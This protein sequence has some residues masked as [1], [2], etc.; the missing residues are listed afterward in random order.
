MPSPLTPIPDDLPFAFTPRE[1]EHLGIG[2]NVLSHPRF[3]R[4]FR[5]VRV[6]GDGSHTALV[7]SARLEFLARSYAPRLRAGE[8]FS[9]GTALVLLG[10]PIRP[11][12]ALDVASPPPLT[13]PRSR[14]VQ[15][16]RVRVAIGSV[17]G[18]W[19]LPVAAPAEAVMQAAAALPFTELVVAIDFLVT[20]QSSRTHLRGDARTSLGE[21]RVKAAGSSRGVRVLRR[22]LQVARVGSA[23]RMETLLRLVLSDAGLEHHF[24]LQRDIFDEHG[25][26]GRFDLVCSAHRLI[27]EYDGEQHRTSREQYVRDEYRLDRVRE[28][29]YRVLR[30]RADDVLRAPHAVADRVAAALRD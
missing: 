3:D 21:L 16:H 11:P 8:V 13:P 25:W 29:G 24:T 4:P 18:R 12:E 7:G 22:A 30:F 9:H 14:G 26:I 20:D 23:S 28:A 1:A 17:S 19:G 10:C 15:G 5:A 27:V 6:R 2:R